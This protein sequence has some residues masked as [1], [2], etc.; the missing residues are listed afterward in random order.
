MGRRTALL[1]VLSCALVQPVFAQQFWEKKPYTQW[2]DK[3][4]RRVLEDSPWSQQLTV[5]N[6]KL[7]IAGPNLSPKGP[8]QAA[9]DRGMEHNPRITYT[10]QFRS[11]KP[12]RQALIRHAQIA[13]K[14]D[15]MDAAKKAAADQRAQEFLGVPAEEIMVYVGFETNVPA[16]AM[17]IQRAFSSLPPGTVPIDTFLNVGGNKLSPT[18][19]QVVTGGMQLTFQ[20]P[21]DLPREGDISLEFM[22][23]QVGDV[24]SARAFLRFKLKNMVLAGAPE[25]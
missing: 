8:T 13:S 16:Y 11:A 23:P 2:S 17:D 25:L 3:E 20:R 7:E 12:I 15:Q 9:R 18:S 24:P 10:V 6:V 21:P 14:Y 1:L 5:S 22:S 4:V 19:Y